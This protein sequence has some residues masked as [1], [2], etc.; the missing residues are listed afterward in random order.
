M[1]S[2]RRDGG[3]NVCRMRDDEMALAA[4]PTRVC[5][6]NLADAF[7][8]LAEAQALARLSRRPAAPPA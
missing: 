1:P 4:D 8:E 5:G 6:R 3:D 2:R 7:V